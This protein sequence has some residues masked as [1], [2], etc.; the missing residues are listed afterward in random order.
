MIVFISNNNTN[1]N[2]FWPVLSRTVTLRGQNIPPWWVCGR[3][4]NPH[5]QS[6]PVFS[7]SA[8]QPIVIVIHIKLDYYWIK[9]L[10]NTNVSFTYIR[11]HNTLMGIFL[12][13]S[14]YICK[15]ILLYT[16]TYKIDSQNKSG[17]FPKWHHCLHLCQ[18]EFFSQ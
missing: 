8:H 1:L 5:C 10:Q 6:F 9:I 4:F 12:Q 18:N 15:Y 2:D 16:R 11:F 3:R 13:R 14:E 7:R 17:A